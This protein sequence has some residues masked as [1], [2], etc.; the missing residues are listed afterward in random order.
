[1]EFFKLVQN[2]VTLPELFKGLV[3]SRDIPEKPQDIPLDEFKTGDIYVIDIQALNDRG[4]QMVFERVL[5]RLF[6]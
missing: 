1:M 4:Q 5:K 6:E 3:N 2:L